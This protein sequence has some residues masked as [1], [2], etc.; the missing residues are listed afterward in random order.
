[1]LVSVNILHISGKFI[2][3]VKSRIHSLPIN[4]YKKSVVFDK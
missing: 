1:M 4:L 2:R 3:N